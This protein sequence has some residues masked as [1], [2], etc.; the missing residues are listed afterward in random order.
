M[1]FRDPLLPVLLMALALTACKKDDQPQPQTPAPPAD[2]EEVITTLRITFSD[3]QLGTEFDL[4]FEDADGPGGNDPVITADGLPANREYAAIVRVWNGSVSPPIDMTDEIGEEDE[5][6]QLFFQVTGAALSV[7]YADLD[8]NGHPVGLVN[9][10][11]TG[12]VGTGSL[13]V[14]LRHGPDKGAAG[15][16]QGDITNA[17]GETDIEVTFPVEIL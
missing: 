12:D 15:V 6:H 13:K 2:E 9:L 7:Q 3:I 5:A 8:D 10:A 14:T 11:S 16:A 1:N 17:G 4:L